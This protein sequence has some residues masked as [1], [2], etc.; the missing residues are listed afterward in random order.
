MPTQYQKNP[1]VK[2]PYFYRETSLE[3]KC[4]DRGDLAG[5]TGLVGESTV[6]C[7]STKQEK[8][9]YMM[10]FCKACYMG[11]EIYRAFDDIERYRS[12]NER[13]KR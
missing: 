11:C 6:S 9:E 13:E 3:I 8:R 10:D 5:G 4:K 2:C 1:Y 12:G 7:F